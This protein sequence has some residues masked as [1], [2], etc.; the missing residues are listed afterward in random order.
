MANKR[1]RTGGKKLS[2]GYK[3]TL[4]IMGII[5]FLAFAFA[6]F[7]VCGGLEL[8]TGPQHTP[9]QLMVD[10]DG[11]YYY[12]DAEGNVQYLDVSSATDVVSD[13]VVSD[14]TAAVE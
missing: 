1:R 8:I 9:F 12:Y 14:S 11:S 6:I 10:D 7:T 3:V 2:K 4:W 13:T 5:L